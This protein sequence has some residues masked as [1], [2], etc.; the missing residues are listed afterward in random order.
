MLI[1]NPKTTCK[2]PPMPVR[3]HMDLQLRFM[4]NELLQI[5]DEYLNGGQLQHLKISTNHA[6][7]SSNL[8]RIKHHEK[9]E[10]LSLQ[11]CD[12]GSPS[13][14]PNHVQLWIYCKC[15]FVFIWLFMC[16]SCMKTGIC[17]QNSPRIQ[18]AQI[19]AT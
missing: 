9:D 2:N 3:N 16:Y 1:I 10:K 11:Q 8:N 18:L 6:R 5:R 15:R 7:K 14:P 4:Q 12:R 13:K 17:L 19:Y